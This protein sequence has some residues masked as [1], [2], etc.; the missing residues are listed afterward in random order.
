MNFRIIIAVVRNPEQQLF[1]VHQNGKTIA[2]ADMTA[3]HHNSYHI[4]QLK[5]VGRQLGVW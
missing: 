5:T 4:G 1:E 2:W 3:L